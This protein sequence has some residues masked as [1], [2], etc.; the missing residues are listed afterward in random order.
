MLLVLLLCLWWLLQLFAFWLLVGRWWV[1]GNIVIAVFL[2]AIVVV[3][4]AADAAAA[5]VSFAAGCCCSP[6]ILDAA[7]VAAA[8]ACRFT[9]SKIASALHLKPILVAAA[10]NVPSTLHLCANGADTTGMAQPRAPHVFGASSLQARPSNCALAKPGAET[11]P[12][13]TESSRGTGGVRSTQM[14]RCPG[15]PL[16]NPQTNS[17]THMRVCISNQTGDAVGP[18]GVGLLAFGS[19]VAPTWGLRQGRLRTW[20]PTGK[21]TAG[22]SRKPRGT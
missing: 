21:K 2:A 3:V 18:A 4:A 1:I 22:T 12:E 19:H 9:M 11:T 13:S 7:P 6:R 5:A 8:V 10:S 20:A 14:F 16:G 15:F 17:K